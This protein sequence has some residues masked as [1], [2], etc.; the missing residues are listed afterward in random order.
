MVNDNVSHPAHYTSGDIECIDAI[1]ASLGEE[2]FKGY[3]RGNIQKYI[4]RYKFKGGSEDLEKA[5]WYLHMLIAEEGG[6]VHAD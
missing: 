6:I 5:H 1:K 3:L 4:W 2:E